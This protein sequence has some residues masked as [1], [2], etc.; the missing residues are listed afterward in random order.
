MKRTYNSINYDWLFRPTGD[1]FADA[2]G[3]ALK[4]FE[5]RYPES[6]VLEIIMKATDIYVDKWNGKIN[7]FFLNSKI[8]QPAFD[9]KRKKEETKK[10]F[11]DLLTDETQG[12]IGICR[13][14]GEKTKLYPAGRDNT[15]LSGSGTLVNFHHTFQEGIMLSK[16]AIIRYHFLPLGCELLIGRVAVIH[17]NNQD[18]TKQ[19]ASDCCSRN[20]RNVGSGLSDGI[21]KSQSR[22]PGT[23]LF[24]FMDNVISEVKKTDNKNNP[25]NLISLYHFT[26]FGANPDVQIYTLPFDVFK[27]YR[28]TQINATIKKQWNEFVAGYYSNADYKKAKFY[29]DTSTFIYEDKNETIEVKEDDFKFWRN[30][31]YERLIYN[32]SIVPQMLKRSREY[33]LSWEL[34]KIYE[35]YIR[36]M[37]KETLAK[38]EQMADFILSSNDERT[39]TKAIKKLDGVKNSYLLRRFILKDIVAK[40]Y[41]EGN[42]EAIVTIE[43]YAEY[44]FPDTN[45]WQETRDVLLIAIYQKMHER[46]MYVDTEITDD[47]YLEND[48]ENNEQ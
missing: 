33:E 29:G 32:Q 8:T 4:E 17:S 11:L 31:I 2:G 47:E 12:N 46:K 28:T 13:I 48:L 44:L 20:L 15:V 19:F 21:L 23:A 34:I 38:I 37:K 5:K 14:M 18:I 6:D 7:P 40:Y 16:E 1:P 35:Q 22:A 10:Y 43:D 25:Q 30:S 9:L 24:R 27:F 3:Y 42:D 45:S 41:N 39:I 36:K 26:N